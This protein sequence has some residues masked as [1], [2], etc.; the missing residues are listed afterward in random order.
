MSKRYEISAQESVDALNVIDVVFYSSKEVR[1][2]W[3]EFN[4]AT[5]LPDSPTKL[6]EIGDKHLKL[7]EVMADD[8]GYKK[9]RWDDIKHYYFPVALSNK[10]NEEAVLRK[11]QIDAS[12]AQN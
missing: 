9:I 2:A 4:E 3:N 5:T 7:L 10:M 11:V 6:Q 8:I 12:L 1:E